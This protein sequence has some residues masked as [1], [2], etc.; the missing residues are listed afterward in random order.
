VF[1]AFP[2]DADVSVALELDDDAGAP[3]E[4]P[5]TVLQEPVQLFTAPAFLREDI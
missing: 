1:C 3:G 5:R 4:L 2:E